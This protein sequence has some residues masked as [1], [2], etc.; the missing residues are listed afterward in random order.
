MIEITDQVVAEEVLVETEDLAD[1]IPDQEKNFTQFVI[2][3]EKIAKFRL[4]PVA[5]SL[6]T[7]A[8]VLKN[9]VVEIQG[10]KDLVVDQIDLKIQIKNY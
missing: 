1:A 4:N 5:I 3:V 8:T 2:I 9:K 6:F 10:H 7:V